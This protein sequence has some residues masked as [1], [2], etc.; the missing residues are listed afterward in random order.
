ML[1]SQAGISRVGKIR[2]FVYQPLA[3]YQYFRIFRRKT[4]SWNRSMDVAHT[5]IQGHM[6]NCIQCNDAHHAIVFQIHA[7]L[8]SSCH[9][10][11]PGMYLHLSMA[12]APIQYDERATTWTLTQRHAVHMLECAHACSMHDVQACTKPAH[13]HSCGRSK[14]IVGDPRVINSASVLASKPEGMLTCLMY[15]SHQGSRCS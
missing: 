3:K 1:A 12:C 8:S 11:L 2:I 9:H 7:P 13:S 6:Y 10:A 15:P 14:W 5:T 4:S